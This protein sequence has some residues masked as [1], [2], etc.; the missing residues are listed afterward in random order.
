MRV[1]EGRR[2]RGVPGKLQ[3]INLEATLQHSLSVLITKMIIISI[4]IIMM[5]CKLQAKVAQLQ[6]VAWVGGPPPLSSDFEQGIA[7]M[8]SQYVHLSWL[9]SML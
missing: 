5:H 1:R 4:I 7:D 9:V 6:T 2:W 8:Q 3:E